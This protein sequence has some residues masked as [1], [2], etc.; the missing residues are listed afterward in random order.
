MQQLTTQEVINLRN[1]EMDG[2]LRLPSHLSNSSA[3]D[4]EMRMFV[5]NMIKRLLRDFGKYNF[6]S[7][8]NLLWKTALRFIDDVKD[9]RGLGTKARPYHISTKW[10]KGNF[11]NAHYLFNNQQ[12]P[13]YVEKRMCF[14]NSLKFALDADSNNEEPCCILSGISL[15]NAGTGLHSVIEKN[16]YIIDFNYDLVMDARLYKEIFRF[17]VLA[18]LSSENLNVKYKPVVQNWEFANMYG[19]A[20][21]NFASEDFLKYIEGFS[22]SDFEF[23]IPNVEVL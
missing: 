3:Q 5:S 7:P 12:Y 16:G 17:E 20:C 19:P 10:G 9:L 1:Q 13:K 8:E 22:R 23:I 11:F 21:F 2:T 15:F 4:I 18:E 14:S 6:I